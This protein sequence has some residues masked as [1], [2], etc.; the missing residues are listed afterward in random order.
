MV[1][2]GRDLKYWP[3]LAMLVVGVGMFASAV[4]MKGRELEAANAR[5]QAKIEWKKAHRAAANLSFN[6]Q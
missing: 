3:A 2:K 4:Q 1:I 5:R 6:D